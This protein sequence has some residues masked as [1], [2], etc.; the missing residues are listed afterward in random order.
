MAEPREELGFWEHLDVLRGDLVRI[1]LAT[2]L[3]SVVAFLFKDGLFD[4][5]FAPK[6]P[7]FITYRLINRLAAIC[8]AEP[9]PDFHVKLINT[10]LAQQFLV[11]V[12]TALCAG[13]LCA[14][15]YIIYRLFGFVAPAL[16]ARERRYA[17]RTVIGGYAMFII[18]VAL[19]Y[20]VIF[21]VTF[22]FLGTYQVSADVTNMIDLESYMSTLIMMC[23]CLGVV[24]EL[25]VVAWLL[26]KAGI[27]T[28]EFMRRYRR[29]AIVVILILAAIITPTSDVFTLTLVALPVWLLYEAS[30]LLIRK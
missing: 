19:S 25:P 4:V 2:L 20:F 27:L 8:G 24:C 28:P 9:L 23:L 7:D 13:V 15:P 16:Y 14:S 6:S 29:H 17:V 5:V 22:Q 18:G 30:I 26:G 11:H 1:A 3:C 21:P 10:G 12:K